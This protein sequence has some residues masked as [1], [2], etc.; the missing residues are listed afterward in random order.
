[1]HILRVLDRS[2]V[3]DGIEDPETDVSVM[4]GIP[5]EIASKGFKLLLKAKVLTLENGSICMPKFIEAQETPK[6]DKL[7]QRESRERRRAMVGLKTFTKQQAHSIVSRAVLNGELKKEPCEKCGSDS[8]VDAHHDDYD[9][10]LSV[11]WLCRSCHGKTHRSRSVTESH[12]KNTSVTDS[13][14]LPCLADPLP[15]V[16][17]PYVAIQTKEDR[18]FDKKDR[19]KSG[20]DPYNA[21]S[22]PEFIKLWNACPRKQGQHPAYLA[23][24]DRCDSMTTDGLVS[25]MEA[26]AAAGMIGGA[27]KLQLKGWIEGKRWC[28]EVVETD[29]HRKS[30]EKRSAELGSMEIARARENRIARQ[31][32]AKR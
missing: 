13:H 30:E 3:L 21:N 19:L 15:C 16:A 17:T 14:S 26:Q 8:H 7:R 24:Q 18:V 2:G 6:S 20:I 22:D 29:D 12:E 27:S 5:E 11:N 31:K 10:P 9:S 4:T 1:M 25:A 32:A 28:D 23:W